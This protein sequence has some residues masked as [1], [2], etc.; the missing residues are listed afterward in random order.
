MIKGQKWKS[1]PKRK[2]RTKLY[3]KKK[4]GQKQK[5]KIEGRKKSA[6]HFYIKWT[7][8]DETLSAQ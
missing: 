3:K 5:N 4:L 1:Q 8:L 6:K 7:F 2:E